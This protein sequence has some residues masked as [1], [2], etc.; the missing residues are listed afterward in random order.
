[1]S[2]PTLRTSAEQQIH[3][4]LYRYAELIDGAEFEE[5]A[6]LFE[7]AVFRMGTRE[8]T[9]QE[10]LAH[11]KNLTIVHPDGTLRTAHLTT[12]LLVELDHSGTTATCR[13]RFTVLQQTD[14]LA[15][16]PICSG[17]YHDTFAVS[18]AGTW[19]FTSRSYA[20][21]LVGN[22]SQHMRDLG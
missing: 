21:P 7:R 16:Q 19:Y 15:L 1:M 3:N 22:T 4:L 20:M 9:P 11:W 14:T 12:N 17:R 6:A 5:C 10:M 2:S 8:V 18:E 13:S